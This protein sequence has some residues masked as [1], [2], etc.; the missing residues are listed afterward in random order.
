MFSGPT[1]ALQQ[2]QQIS[3]LPAQHTHC[4]AQVQAFQQ[5]PLLL[6]A[7][8]FWEY[9]ENQKLLRMSQLLKLEGNKGQ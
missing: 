1:G 3:S 6:M 9:D 7:Q 2:D 4:A 5:N 8:K